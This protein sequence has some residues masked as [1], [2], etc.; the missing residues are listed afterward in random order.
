MS[1]A[2]R[3]HRMLLWR[4]AGYGLLAIYASYL[5]LA[6]LMLNSSIGERIANLKPEK[7]RAAWSSAWSLYPGHVHVRGLKLA[8]HV[9]RTV[10]SVQAEEASGRVALL[11]LLSRQVRIPVATGRGVTGGASRIDVERPRPEPG[12][13][14]WTLRFDRIVV[15]SAD[16]AYFNSLLLLGSGRAEG[17]FT[18]VLRGGPMELTPSTVHFS[19]SRLIDWGEELLHDLAVDGQFAIARHLSAEVPGIRKLEMMDIDLALDGAT[20]GLRVA[21]SANHRPR[22]AVVEGDGRISGKL[23]WRRGALLDGGRLHVEMPVAYDINGQKDRDVLRTALDVGKGDIRLVGALAARGDSPFHADVALRVAGREIPL[24]GWQ[25]VLAR[26][27]GEVKAQWRFDSLA[28]L[29]AFV[30][31]S[32]IVSF[33]GAGTVRAD[34]KIAAGEVAPGSEVTVPRVSASVVALGNRFSGAADARIHFG[35]HG[36]GSI[37]PRLDAV[38]E[39]FSMAPV[40]TP[41]QPYVQGRD[42]RITAQAE[43]VLADLKSRYTARLTFNDATVPDLRVYNRYLPKARI[44]IDGG[45]GLLSGELDFDGNDQVASGVMRVQGRGTRLGFAMLEFEGD[46]DVTTRL[47]RGDLLHDSFDMSGSTLVLHNMSVSDPDGPVT[48]DWWLEAELP[49]ARLDWGKPAVV[50]G[51]SRM[52]MKDVSALLALYEQKKKLPNWIGK[53]LD[54]GEATAEGRIRWDGGRLVLDRVRA[55]N[56]RF[57]VDA[58]LQ[59]QEKQLRGDLFARWGMLS[60]GIDVDGDKKD[61][62][63]VRARKWFDAQPAMLPD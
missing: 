37:A 32:K 30:P 3:D 28:W 43:G 50:D 22:L 26:T 27:D 20:S 24:P 54:T 39:A 2:A 60:L 16:Y 36:S 57:D 7:F 11:P 25:Q 33:D 14:G 18:K 63:L 6:N 15:E 19:S 13:G 8:G 46:L 10:W 55:H 53:L 23:G 5:L 56:D 49:K 38:M 42:L 51:E 40:A 41:D 1:A 58:R 34:L 31:G 4:R 35:A 45:S 21:A 52:R 61:L 48:T 47:R 17:G 59:V 29:G 12:P 62:H 44:S 9:R